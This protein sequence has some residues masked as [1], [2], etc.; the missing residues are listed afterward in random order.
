MWRRSSK[1]LCLLLLF[2]AALAA[3]TS[4]QAVLPDA[5]Q[6][7]AV[8]ELVQFPDD[9]DFGQVP[10][11]DTR[12]IRYDI[13]NTKAYVMHWQVSPAPD[14]PFCLSK[15]DSDG[16]C[17][18]PGGNMGMA[19]VELG[20]AYS[21]LIGFSPTTVGEQQATITFDIEWRL[22]GIELEM[23]TG[24]ETV[25]LRGEGIDGQAEGELANPQQDV[26]PGPTGGGDDDQG[27][28]GM[29]QEDVKPQPSGGEAAQQTEGCECAEA[30]LGA[31]TARIA[32]LESAVAQLSQ[33]LAGTVTAPSI[34]PLSEIPSIEGVW[35]SHFGLLYDVTQH[36]SAFAWYIATIHE[37]GTGTI[38]GTSLTVS[39]NGDNGSGSDTGQLV[40]GPDGLVIAIEM[41]NGNRLYR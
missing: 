23:F 13:V 10:V 7:Q 17:M 15:S 39:W 4:G 22:G 20:E 31:L 5:V 19:L 8:E 11:G 1:V 26:L 35:S 18:R 33:L 32:A 9:V 40:L 16:A 41:R 37:W 27:F 30:E 6:Q 14:A 28:K 24:S 29:Q 3:A 2:A 36:G 12:W 25:V 34:A 38:E 21:F